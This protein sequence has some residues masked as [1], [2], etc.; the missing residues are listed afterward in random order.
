MLL[1][2][3]KR[4]VFNF[5]NQCFDRS[6]KNRRKYTSS[7]SEERDVIQPNRTPPRSRKTPTKSFGDEL[8]RKL[9]EENEKALA[10]LKLTLAAQDKVY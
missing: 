3:N 4:Y 6:K 7:S 9:K 2:C 8:R 1:L 5:N 10:L